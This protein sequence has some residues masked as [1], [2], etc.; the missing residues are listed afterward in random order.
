MIVES[1]STGGG[2]AYLKF[3][4]Q[5]YHPL[6]EKYHPLCLVDLSRDRLKTIE[7][8]NGRYF[9]KLSLA[10][11]IFKADFFISLAKMK[12]HNMTTVTGAIKNLFGCLPDSDKSGY[13]LRLDDVIA[14]VA[15]VIKVSLGIVDGNPGMDG[16]GPVKG[17]PIQMNRIILGNNPVATDAVMSYVMG[18]A[19]RNVKHLDLVSRAAAIS[20]DL[21]DIALT[22]SSLEESRVEVQHIG[23]VQ[24]K[25][26]SEGVRIQKLGAFLY[27]LGHMVHFQE[28]VKQVLVAVARAFLLLV[29]SKKTLRKYKRMLLK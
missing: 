15:S 26:V 24:R 1:D 12:T 29:F 10:E 2:Y 7:M 22:G 20:L 27:Q 14:D 16:N 28:N 5:G 19:P 25:I 11:S 18:V 13:H 17:R 8:E 9:E 23:M 6:I 21:S 4:K 3:E